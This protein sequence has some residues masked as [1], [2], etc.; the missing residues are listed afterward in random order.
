MLLHRLKESLVVCHGQVGA[1]WG[2]L[3]RISGS[4][5]LAGWQWLSVVPKEVLTR[6]KCPGSTPRPLSMN[7]LN[8][9]TE[10]LTQTHRHPSNPQKVTGRCTPGTEAAGHH[11]LTSALGTQLQLPLAKY[12]CPQ[13]QEAQNFWGL[14]FAC[15]SSSALCWQTFSQASWLMPHLFFLD[16]FFKF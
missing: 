3:E 12:L 9:S 6:H 14:H 1:G 10:K 11:L 16:L 15:L 5:Q 13:T 8:H 2:H 4:L 7:Q